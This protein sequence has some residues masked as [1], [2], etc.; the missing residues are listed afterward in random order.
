MRYAVKRLPYEADG[1]VLDEIAADYAAIYL[2]HSI[3]AS[4]YESV[5]FDEENLVR[6]ASMFQV[7][8]WYRRY[9]LA[10][11]DWRNRADDHLTLQLQFLAHLFELGQSDETFREVAQFM[12]EHLLR[13]IG[14]FAERVAS[15]CDTPFFAGLA[16]LTAVYCEELRDVLVEVLGQPRPSAQEIEARMKPRVEPATV[17]LKFM[18]GVGPTV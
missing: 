9:D 18:P 12:D 17:P 2:N 16:L 8:E 10:A 1:E 11:P 15:R 13:W 5:W 4:P 7:R 6:Q 3:Q 14:S